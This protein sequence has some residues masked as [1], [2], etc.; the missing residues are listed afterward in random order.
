MSDSLLKC[1]ICDQT[2]MSSNSQDKHYLTQKHKI[3]KKL[4]DLTN[5]NKNLELEKNKLNSEFNQVKE[6]FNSE[7]KEIKSK[8]NEANLRINEI[9]QMFLEDINSKQLNKKSNKNNSNYLLYSSASIGILVLSFLINR[10]R[11]N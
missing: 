1:E 7:T 10:L 6:N 4:F 8:L 9:S 2:F 11:M 3:N 5:K